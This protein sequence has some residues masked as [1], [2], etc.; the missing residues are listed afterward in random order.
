VIYLWWIGGAPADGRVLASAGR[1]LEAEFARPVRLWTSIERPLDT[2][3]ARRQQ[4]SSRAVLHWLVEARPAGAS[5]VLGLTDV[6]LFMPVLTFVF[7][8]A[9]LD[10]V[11]AVVSTARLVDAS[12]AITEARVVTECVHE[13]GHTF[14]LLHCETPGCVMTRSAS[15]RAVDAK[16]PALC[17]LCRQRYRAYDQEGLHVYHE[18]ADSDRR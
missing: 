15:V 9:Q 14:G 18:D 16:R 1:R 7:G 3:D 11:A 5:R 6:D 4:H 13:L 2:F 8:E 17:A 12:A 10:G